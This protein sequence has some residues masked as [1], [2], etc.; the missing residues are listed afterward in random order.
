MLTVEDSWSWWLKTLEVDGWRHLKLTVLQGDMNCENM[1]TCFQAFMRYATCHFLIGFCTRSKCR[2]VFRASLIYIIHLSTPISTLFSQ[3][4]LSERRRQPCQSNSSNIRTRQ[5]YIRQL[6]V[7]QS[8]EY[9]LLL[10]FQV[11]RFVRPTHPS[12]T[13]RSVS[14]RFC[15]Q[16]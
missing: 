13:I 1:L 11:L 15:H 16:L 14:L 2:F 12:V 6:S 3:N 9:L 10:F 4:I 7:T 5:L 8:G